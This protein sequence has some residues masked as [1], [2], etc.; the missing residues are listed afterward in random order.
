MSPREITSK[1]TANP[2]FPIASGIILT[3]FGFLLTRSAAA[4]DALKQEMEEKASIKYVDEKMNE[5]KKE[6]D[7]KRDADF[8]EIMTNIQYIKEGVDELKHK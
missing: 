7:A 4:T 1:V 6:I 2:L 8:R 5:T 3:L